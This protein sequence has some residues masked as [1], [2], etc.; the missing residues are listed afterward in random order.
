MVAELK[1]VVA[2]MV[3]RVWRQGRL[4]ELERFWTGDCVN[5][6]APPG[7]RHGIEELRRYHETFAAGLAD[8]EDVRIAIDDQVAEDDRVCTRLRTTARHAPTGRPAT[9][10]TIRIDRIESG[11]IAEHWSVAD[12]AGLAAQLQ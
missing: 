8:F 5:H 1:Q 4:D 10:A 6:A 3:E 9:L 2:D 11:R 7:H 12:L